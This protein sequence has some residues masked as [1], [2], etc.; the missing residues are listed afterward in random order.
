MSYKEIAFY[1]IIVV[2]L[3]A[4]TRKEMNDII[5]WTDSTKLQYSDFNGIP[6][7]E[8]SFGALSFINIEVDYTL[9][10]GTL[11]CTIKTT[12]D[13]DSSWIKWREPASLNHE[14]THFDI[15]E[16]CARRMRKDLSN[17]STRQMSKNVVDSIIRQHLVN[18]DEIQ[19]NYDHETEY[20]NNKRAQRT[21]DGKVKEWL[22]QL[23]EY[24]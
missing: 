1:S 5:Y 11:R 15:A 8:S 4:Y 6:P 19:N 3:S 7:D 9:L 13:S 12:F 17:L 23:Q 21:W 16:S 22:I 14:Q 24:K 10:N 18:C 2:L 20:S